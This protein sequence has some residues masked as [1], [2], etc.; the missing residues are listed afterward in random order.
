MEILTAGKV[1]AG[2]H[3]V[4]VTEATCA[5]MEANRQ[6]QNQGKGRPMWRISSTM[7]YHVNSDVILEPMPGF[8]DDRD[9]YKP[10]LCGE[11]VQQ[12]LSGINLKRDN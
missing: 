10:I 1:L 2:Y 8:E 12:E 7:F 11:Y 5:A 4:V 9:V 3:E 6:L